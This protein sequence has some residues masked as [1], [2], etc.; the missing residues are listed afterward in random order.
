MP[1][2]QVGFYCSSS[3]PSPRAIGNRTGTSASQA[4]LW[5]N[6]LGL[7]SPACE[8]AYSHW[9]HLFA[10]SPMCFFQLFPQIACQRGCIVTLVAFVWLFSTVC[11][12]MFP[13]IVCTRGC[14]VT[15]QCDYAS[16]CADDLN[17]LVAFVWLFSTVC[18]Q[19]FP[20]IA[21]MSGCIVTLFAF[22]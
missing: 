16:S 20:Q 3:C 15:L 1:F 4:R 18:S 11:F 21:C 13:Q 2:L 5:N 9:L 10:F 7:Q 17:A 8:D 6:S 14:I 19:M 12:Q 22:V